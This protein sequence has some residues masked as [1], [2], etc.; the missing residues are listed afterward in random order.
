MA[1]AYRECFFY[2]GAIIDAE[3]IGYQIHDANRKPLG[4][5]WGAEVELVTQDFILDP[6]PKLIPLNSRGGFSLDNR[7]ELTTA[8]IARRATYFQDFL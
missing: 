2:V 8:Y 5:G 3:N 1:A 7:N 4:M 6:L